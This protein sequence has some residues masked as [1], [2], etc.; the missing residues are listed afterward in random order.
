MKPI[1]HEILEILGDAAQDGSGLNNLT[2]EFRTGRD[3]NEIFVLLNSSN[4]ELVSCGLCLLG[5]LHFDLYNTDQ[6]IS[7]LHDLIEHQTPMIRSQAF[8]ALFPA[9]LS[10]P[11]PFDATVTD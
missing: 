7:R 5:E 6:F 4:T 10:F 3:A 9:P 8:A 11:E 1:E 2:D